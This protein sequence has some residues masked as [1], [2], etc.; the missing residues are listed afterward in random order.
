MSNVLDLFDQTVFRRRAS[1]RSHQPAAV[2]LGVQ[3]RDRHRRSAPVPSPSSAGAVIAPH[4]TL[5]VAV[6]PP[7]LGLAQRS[8]RPGDRRDAS[9][10]RRIRRLARRAGQH[11]PRRRARTRMAPRGA[12]VHRRRRRGEPGHLPLP[13]RR[14]RALR[15]VGGR[16]FRP[17]R[18]DQ[19]ACCRLTPAV[20]S[21]ARGRPPNRARHP[22]YR[23]R[24]R[25]RSTIRPTS[26]RRADR[27]RH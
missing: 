12:A 16:G 26:P 19:L 11:S 4:R 20:A 10:A 25:R 2:R 17:P 23:P 8:V 13:H 1:D 21:A 5:T 3:P 9:A 15:G 22:R 6:R 24:R 7:S 14:R 18:P 27:L